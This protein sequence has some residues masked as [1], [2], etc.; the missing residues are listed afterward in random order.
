MSAATSTPR[1]ITAGVIAAGADRFERPHRRPRFAVGVIA[2]AGDGLAGPADG[3]E[4][5]GRGSQA[6]ARHAVA[7]S[8]GILIIRVQRLGGQA[9]RFL[10]SA[11]RMRPAS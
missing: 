9:R 10:K 11:D 5:A 3:H 6:E 1:L 8:I 4:D 7:D 2:P